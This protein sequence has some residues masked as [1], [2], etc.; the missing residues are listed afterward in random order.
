LTNKCLIRHEKSVSRKKKSTRNKQ[1]NPFSFVFHGI[2]KQKRR[3]KRGKFGNKQAISTEWH[4]QK[5][6]TPIPM[7]EQQQE[8]HKQADKGGGHKKGGG[9]DSITRH[10][11]NE[12]YDRSTLLP[13]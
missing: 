4:Q 8:E 3:K 6:L 5:Q 12:Y 10:I 7:S 1:T 2:E 13:S 9:K 11:L